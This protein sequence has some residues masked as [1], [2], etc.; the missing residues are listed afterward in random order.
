MRKAS[1]AVGLLLAALVPV[2]PAHSGTCHHAY[3]VEGQEPPAFSGP[4][5]SIPGFVIYYWAWGANHSDQGSVSAPVVGRESGVALNPGIIWANSDKCSG[6]IEGTG[7]LVEAPTAS[8]GGSFAL[9]AVDG[10][11]G[12]VDALQAGSTQCVAQVIPR[13]M[14][15]GFGLGSDGSGDYADVALRW[16]TPTDEAWAV[17]TISPVLAGYGVYYRTGSS[18][19]NGDKTQFA[20]VGA[21]PSESAPYVV[22]D[23]DGL[24]PAAQ[25]SCTVRI[26][27]GQEYYFAVSLIFDGSG[28]TSGNPQ[29][30]ESA[31]ETVY[32]SAC[33]DGVAAEN[34]I[35]YDGFDSGDTSL[36]SAAW[37]DGLAVTVTATHTGTHGLEVTVGSSCTSP[38]YLVFNCRGR[39]FRGSQWGR[40]DIHG[41]SV[42]RSRGWVLSRIG[43]RLHSSTRRISQPVHVCPGRL[44]NRGDQL[45]R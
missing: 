10:A 31:V 33:S 32:V 9:L 45:Q 7:V 29:A 43:Q 15:T 14:V 11:E 35:F 5:P 19:D 18:V 40:C 13:P 44:S 30:D 2:S 6:Q 39:Q 28:A 21:V 38:E 41:G 8:A 24:L 37:A 36:W 42:H 4:T 26:R 1:L 12:N 20:P 27:P 34:E 23:D 3:V 17:S 22:D 16:T 25:T